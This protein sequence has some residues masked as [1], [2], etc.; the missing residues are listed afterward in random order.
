M[1]TSTNMVI[2][3]FFFC[4]RK[5][6]KHQYECRGSSS[7]SHNKH[8]QSEFTPPPIVDV[9]TTTNGRKFKEAFLATCGGNYSPRAHTAQPTCAVLPYIRFGSCFNTLDIVECRLL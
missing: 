9:R 6:N 1:R 4:L 8:R 5:T 3:C 7:L 2:F